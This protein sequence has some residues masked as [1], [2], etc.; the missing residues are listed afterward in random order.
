MQSPFSG[1]KEV[2]APQLDN[3]KKSKVVFVSDLHRSDY[4]GG[5]E[6]STDALSKTS[7]FEEVC[8]LRSQFWL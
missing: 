2:P 8:F 6:L 1:N 7:P 4:A 3:F 5:A